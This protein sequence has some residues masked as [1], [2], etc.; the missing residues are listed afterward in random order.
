MLGAMRVAALLLSATALLVLAA[1]GGEETRVPP[2]VRAVA[3]SDSAVREVKIV[4]IYV[5]AAERI[6]DP[7]PH[8]SHYIDVDVLSGD[9]AG[10]PLILPYDTWNVGKP[11]PAVGTVVVMSPIDWVRRDPAKQGRPFDGQ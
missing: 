3:L 11:P 8:I 4:K 9:G 10:K 2:T 6:G 1:C 7:D 5:Q